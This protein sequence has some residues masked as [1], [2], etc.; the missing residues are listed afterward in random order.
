M[1][2][3]TKP[4]TKQTVDVGVISKKVKNL[5]E[6]TEEIANKLGIYDIRKKWAKEL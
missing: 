4:I 1:L 6:D 2:D 3:E 5:Y